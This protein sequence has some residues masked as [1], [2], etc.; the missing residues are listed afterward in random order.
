[1]TAPPAPPPPADADGPVPGAPIRLILV[2][3]ALI[4]LGPL[5]IDM[6][7][8]A[9]PDIE[10]D[11]LTT[12][13]AVQLT[14]TGTLLGLAAGQ[15]LIGPLSDAYGRRRPLIAG[16]MVH[17][18][19][20][21]ACLVAPNV[22]VLGGLRVLQGFG[23]ASAA[24]VTLA[25]V[26]DLYVGRAAATLLSRL[27]LVLGVGPVL[28]PSLGGLVLQWTTW[29]GVF[30]VLAG[31]GAALVALA[32]V[33]LPET[34]PPERRRR[35]GVGGTVRSF[36]VLARDRVFVGLVLVAGLSMAA[37]FA[38]VSGSSFVLQEQYGLSEQAFAVV[39][40]LG[41][42]GLIAGTQVNARLLDRF[43]PQQLLLWALVAGT[44][45][46]VVLLLTATSGLGGLAGILVPLWAVLAATGVAMPNA[47]ALAL[48]RHGEIAGTAAAMLGAVRFGV[49]A[50]AAPFVGLLGNTSAAM[51]VVVVVTMVAAVAVLVTMVAPAALLSADTDA[52]AP[53]D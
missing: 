6:Y 16:T 49:G 7:L 34:L 25:V 3:G 28:A 27:M 11:L 30:V 17:V 20:S 21:L 40:G 43:T 22:A 24:V 8:P 37:L 50:V 46:S 36:R 1:V 31:I 48:S 35:G 42:V 53:A 5:T 39:F 26:R 47:P 10:A 2:L 33:A 52:V 14:L 4:A 9:L 51:A 19:A 38:Y 12:S 44:G 13:A 23:A 18:A 32:V 45:A 15:L 29:R 41:S